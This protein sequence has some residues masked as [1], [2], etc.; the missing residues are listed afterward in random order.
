[1]NVLRINAVE[2][3][4]YNV[5]GGD[6]YDDDDIFCDR[7]TH[8]VILTGRRRHFFQG[9]VRESTRSGKGVLFVSVGK[10]RKPVAMVLAFRHY[11]NLT[12]VLFRFTYNKCSA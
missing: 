10:Q 2:N 11:K 3:N 7:R 9:E 4:G 1:V 6:E 12:V 8:P 5:V